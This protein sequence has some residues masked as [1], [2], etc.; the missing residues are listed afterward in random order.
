MNAGACNSQPNSTTFTC[1]EGSKDFCAH[2]VPM[3]ISS[4]ELFALDV[5]RFMNG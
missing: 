1:R 3:D 2:N 5:T 4:L